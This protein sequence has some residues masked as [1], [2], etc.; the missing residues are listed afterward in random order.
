MNKRIV[1]GV[2]ATALALTSVAMARPYLAFNQWIN[3]SGYGDASV[4]MHA[5]NMSNPVVTFAGQ[6]VDYFAYYPMPGL[7]QWDALLLYQ[8]ED[9]AIVEG[10]FFQ[11][12]LY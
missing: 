11:D 6:G 12:Y 7:G 1:T 8:V 3:V 4:V 2:L 5:Q 9:G 10:L